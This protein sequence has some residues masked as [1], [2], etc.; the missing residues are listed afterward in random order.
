M[1]MKE[2]KKNSNIFRRY[3]DNLYVSSEV[4]EVM[5]DLRSSDNNELLDK[6][7][8]ETWEE[9]L[10]QDIGNKYEREEYR[11]EAALLLKELKTVRTNPFR[12]IC[13]IAAS[14]AAVVAIAWGAVSY[15]NHLRDT[16]I[17][18]TEVIASSGEKKV[19]TLPDGSVIN[20]NSCT[21]LKYPNRFT[22]G[23]RRVEL[24]GEAYFSVARNPEQ[25]FIV[26]TNH[27]DVK[28][29]GTKFNV[30]AY[31]E[32]EI[33]AV[34]VESGKVQV[35]MPEA[36]MRLV[37]S[38]QALINTISGDY[39]KTKED[40]QRVATWIH[41]NLRFKSTPIHDVA[42]ELE[43]VYNCKIKFAE[44]QEFDNL[45]SGEHDNQTL[46]SVLQSIEYATGIKWRKEKNSYILYK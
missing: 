9:A 13:T 37:A 33:V 25:P 36:M 10:A 27:F 32:D 46:L 3:L 12:K 35:D 8:D 14:V 30:K 19:V 11:R 15:Y 20:L 24:S 45:I 6:L 18:Y 40:D 17:E 23:V 26:K 7:A 34:S 39:R 29:L 43:R 31:K 28:V 2:P 42:K 4:P 1:K 5:K 44:G 38:E 21:H 41:G 16:N 22:K